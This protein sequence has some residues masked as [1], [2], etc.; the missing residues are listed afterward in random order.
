MFTLV[1]RYCTLQSAIIS[2]LVFVS[3][4]S[5]VGS[6]PKGLWHDALWLRC[7]VDRCIERIHASPP[8][9]FGSQSMEDRENL[10]GV[11]LQMY[12]QHKLFSLFD[13]DLAC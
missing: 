3:N 8:D 4:V 13:V 7:C 2:F 10:V 1:R 12:Q 6:Q 9:V 5:D 11:M